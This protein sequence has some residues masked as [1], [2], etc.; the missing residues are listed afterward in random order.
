MSAMMRCDVRKIHDLISSCLQKRDARVNSGLH[1]DKS[2]PVK[3]RL[4]TCENDKRKLD[5]TRTRRG[6]DYAPSR[7]P[8]HRTCHLSPGSTDTRVKEEEEEKSRCALKGKKRAH[9]LYTSTS[10]SGIASLPP[11]TDS[12]LEV[13]AMSE[14][15]AVSSILPT[16]ILPDICNLF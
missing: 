6:S 11:S 7:S 14:G 12:S 4:F 15:W 1:K 9:S 3:L 2:S 5:E 8:S 13:S 10:P 16:P